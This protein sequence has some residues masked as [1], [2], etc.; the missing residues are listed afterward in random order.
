[1][2]FFSI[3]DTRDV[4]CS[5]SCSGVMHPRFSVYGR[6]KKLGIDMREVLIMAEGFTPCAGG[7]T[8]GLGIAL[9]TLRRSLQCSMAAAFESNIRLYVSV[10]RSIFSHHGRLTF[11][12]S[13]H[14]IEFSTLYV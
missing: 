4:R 12:V 13:V 2:A 3:H 11:E 1:M 9:L 7:A 14:S 6:D 5:L 8:G 10:T